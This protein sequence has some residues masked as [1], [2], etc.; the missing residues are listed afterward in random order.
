MNAAAILAIH[1]FEAARARHASAE[2]GRLRAALGARP[3][4]AAWR[5]WQ[6]A[7]LNA[8]R[9]GDVYVLGLAAAAEAAA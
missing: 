7:E 3:T 6:A 2:A 1:E 5:A 8:R 4:P 9:A